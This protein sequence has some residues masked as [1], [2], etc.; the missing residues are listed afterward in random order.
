MIKVEASLLLLVDV[1]EWAVVG[2][3][4]WVWIGT[5]AGWD[6]LMEGLGVSSRKGKLCWC[7]FWAVIDGEGWTWIGASAER[8]LWSWVGIEGC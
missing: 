1:G 8:L 6:W 5:D 3:K 2:G 4:C 7:F